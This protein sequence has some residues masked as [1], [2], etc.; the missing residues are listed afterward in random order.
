MYLKSENFLRKCVQKAVRNS[1]RF[2]IG[3]SLENATPKGPS[4]CLWRALGRLWAA[5][6]RLLGTSWGPLGASWRLLETQSLQKSPQR[7]PKD[8]PRALQRSPKG[9][10]K[11]LKTSPNVPIGASVL[12]L[13]PSCDLFV[14]VPCSFAAMIPK[15]D[16][17][18]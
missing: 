6:G 18:S 15:N 8:L 9:H 5:L 3:F 4:E 16:S 17:S 7:P 14:I 10:P 2:W 1:T 12:F 11:L 13:P